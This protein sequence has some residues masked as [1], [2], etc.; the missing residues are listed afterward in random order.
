MEI[1]FDEKALLDSVNVSP[2]KAPSYKNP[3][4][5]ETPMLRIAT[6]MMVIQR[7]NPYS[8]RMQRIM[9]GLK[10]KERSVLAYNRHSHSFS[11]CYSI[12][13]QAKLCC[14]C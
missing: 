7:E 10:E 2:S 3:S 11:I 9:G 1:G 13:E 6:C 14:S 4:V 5:S 12:T 8:V